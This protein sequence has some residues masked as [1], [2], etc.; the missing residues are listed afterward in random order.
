MKCDYRYGKRYLY[1]ANTATTGQ[2]EP[3]FPSLSIQSAS[4]TSMSYD[5]LEHLSTDTVRTLDCKKTSRLSLRKKS[6]S[7][8]RIRCCNLK[9]CKYCTKCLKLIMSPISAA[10]IL[11]GVCCNLLNLTVS[12]ISSQLLR[13]LVLHWDLTRERLHS[14]ELRAPRVPRH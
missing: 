1:T 13:F 11:V 8:K 2:K 4:S 7:C 12:Q 5:K 9:L 6:A 10:F 14:R 3:E